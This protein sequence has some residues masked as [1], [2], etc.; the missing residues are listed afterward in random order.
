MMER[1]AMG[2]QR[3]R[4]GLLVF[5]LYFTVWG[6]AF[7]GQLRKGEAL[8]AA[9]KYGQAATIYETILKTQPKHE[10]ARLGARKARSGMV[11]RQL[12]RAQAALKRGDDA[13]ALGLAMKARK[14]PLDLEEVILASRIDDTVQSASERAEK[15]VSE[16]MER[17]LFILAAELAQQVALAMPGSTARRKWANDLMSQAKIHFMGLANDFKKRGLMGSAAMQFAMAKRMGGDVA[18]ADVQRF[19]DAFTRP[20][21]FAEPSFKVLGPKKSA[22]SSAEMKLIT[23]E[24]KNSLEPFLDRCGKGT[25]ALNI[26]LELENFS[27]Q[28]ST[29]KT[30][31]VRAL[32]GSKVETTESYEEEERYFIEQKY[33]EYE[34]RKEKREKRDCAPRPGQERGCRTWSEEVEVEVP[35]TRTK[36]VEKKRFVKKTR[37]KKGPFDPSEVVF[38]DVT[39]ITRVVNYRGRVGVA[40]VA[41]SFR[42]FDI[43][44]ESIDSS[45][46][47]VRH[48]R[49]VIPADPMQIK[50]IEAVRQDAL[51]QLSRELSASIE[52]AVAKWGG[53]D[54][55]KARQKMLVGDLA[56]AEELYLGLVALGFQQDAGMRRF[57]KERYGKASGEVLN[58]LRLAL[59]QEV[60]RRRAGQMERTARFPR[61][62]KKRAAKSSEKSRRPFGKRIRQRQVPSRKPQGKPSPDPTGLEDDELQSLEDES[63]GDDAENTQDATPTT[64]TSQDQDS[65]TETPAD[66]ADKG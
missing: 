45:N 33:T 49:V 25:K 5:L 65:D 63:L 1:L 46:E 36:Q 35:I 28:D 13:R 2:T 3:H 39:S 34:K 29:K 21:C 31:S 24:F 47:V 9:K 11:E 59:G 7:Q 53:I 15:K 20:L 17:G 23:A 41:E 55:E 32:P 4:L 51:K 61:R 66:D 57:F 50:P 54:A 38:F 26:R 48:P 12:D 52:K 22:L 6:C 40:G 27:L 56:E 8:L 10:K 19:W 60:Q 58:L 37:P 64:D 43:R 44:T 42:P 62:G 30:Q 18:V 16:W 14:M